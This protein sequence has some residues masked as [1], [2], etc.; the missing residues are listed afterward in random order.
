VTPLTRAPRRRPGAARQHPAPPG[1]PDLDG[2]D[3]I[4]AAAI[5]HFSERGY[6][7]TTTAGVAREAGVTQPLVHHHFGSKE[8]L[9]RAALDALFSEVRGIRVARGGSPTERLLAAAEQFVRFVAARP[10]VTRIVARE[11][12]SPSPRLDELVARHLREPFQRF[13]AAI[14]A[15]QRE[16]VLDPEVRPELL[17]FL[18][19]GAGS[20]LFDVAALARESLGVDAASPQTRDEFV[21]L[22]RTVLRRGLMERR[23]R[24]LSRRAR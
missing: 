15:G 4:L 20:H 9:W 2:R 23:S 10:E 12:A 19:L 13:V 1:L 3:R 8:G 18:L 14:R 21:A 11:G 5:R 6:E 7:G 22:L 24:A 16:G 17:L